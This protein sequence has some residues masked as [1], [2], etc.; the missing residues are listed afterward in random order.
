MQEQPIPNPPVRSG[1]GGWE[2]IQ[3]IRATSQINLFF[4]CYSIPSH[5]ISFPEC[6][7]QYLFTQ[8]PAVTWEWARQEGH[9]TLLEKMKDFA[10]QSSKLRL[11]NTY[12]EKKR[13]CLV[14]GQRAV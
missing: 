3:K 2:Q 8:A 1:Q 11:N 5:S 12:S 14:N 9:S 7:Q 4:Y 6:S 13:L 10:F